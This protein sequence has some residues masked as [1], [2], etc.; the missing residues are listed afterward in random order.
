MNNRQL[1][2]RAALVG[3]IGSA[4]QIMY[5][6]LAIRFGPYAERAGAWDEVL[7]A[8]VSVGMVGGTVGLLALD[9]ARPRWLAVTGALLAIVGDLLRIV[10]SGLIFLGQDEAMYLPFILGGILLLLL[11]MGSLGVAVV[12]GKQLTGWRAWTPLLVPIFGFITAASYSV[13]L[14]THFILLGL[15]GLSWLLVSYVVFER[16]RDDRQWAL[17]ASSG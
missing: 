12:L 11:G 5:G 16:A 10:A 4:L 14:Y 9:V 17:A 15:W 7:W 2:Y 1:A 6:L 3:L 13:D 8:L